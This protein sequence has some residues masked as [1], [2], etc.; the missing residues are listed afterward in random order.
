MGQDHGEKAPHREV[1]TRWDC[2]A[3]P[4]N[5]RILPLGG[6]PTEAARQIVRACAS[7]LSALRDAVVLIPDAHAAADF[8]Q[9]L[10][11]AAGREVLLLPRI[12]TLR[13]WASSVDAGKPVQ[14]RAVREALL[15]AALAGHA[16]LGE[17]DRWAVCSELLALF[18]ELT[19]H[20]VTLP[21]NTREF[22]R[23]V[24]KAYRARSNRSLDFEATLVHELWRLMSRD[25]NS[26]RELD[27]EAAY[28]LRLNALVHTHAPLHVVGVRRFTP[29]EQ[30][31]LERYAEHAPVSVYA[32]S[33][34]AGD[35][36]D[37]TLVAAWPALE[38]THEKAPPMLARANALREAAPASALTGRV[39]VYGA[40][41]AETE[42]RAVDVQVR[43]WL[44]AGKQRIAVIT[45]DRV[46]ARRARALLERA[47]VQV[48]DESG[49]PMAT[50]SA[51]TVLSR[52]LD[53][54]SGDAWHRDL[55][56]LMKSP[57]AF[58][59][60]PRDARQQ[61]VWRLE[62]YVR[63]D[64]VLSGI[65]NFIALAEDNNDAEV[66]QLLARVQ[67]ASHT[68]HALPRARKTLPRWLDALIASLAEIG[69][70][71][72]WRADSAGLQVFDL[73]DNLR[74]ELKENTLALG[75]A[76]WRRWLLR[77]LEAAS[78]V[79]SS[80]TSPV[81]FTHLGATPLRAFDA[82]LVLGC[83]A[84]HLGRGG[85]TPLFFNQSVRAQLGLPTRQ[86]EARDSEALLA[87]LVAST[88]RVVFTWQTHADA[89]E[90]LLAPPVERLLSLH[91]CAYNNLLTE[92]RLPALLAQTSLRC[93]DDS[94]P[95]AV[96]TKPAPPADNTLIPS[97]ISASSYN[98]LM[99]CPYQFHAR[100]LLRLGEVDEVEELID[101]SGYGRHVHAILTAFHQAHARVSDLD[102]AQALEQIEA[103][104]EQT[105][106]GAVG[107]NALAR[108][109]LMRWKSLIPAYLEWQRAREA[110]GWR[111]LAGEAKRELVIRTPVGR[112]FKLVGRLDR[113]DQHDSGAID[114]LDYKT[115]SVEALKKSLD[116]AGEDVQLPV[117]AL[118]WAQP[119]MAALYLSMDRDEIKTVAVPGDLPDIAHATRERLAQ[120]V[121]ALH[122][123]SPLPAQGAPQACDYCEMHGLCRR[124][125][126]A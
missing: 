76:E 59:D 90:N 54:V 24:E 19:R 75:F 108:G 99:T 50:T 121:D 29:A 103:L 96:A 94:A 16:S 88:P 53:V 112:E 98:T 79:E 40:P 49:W 113:V 84:R 1:A 7:D 101:K 71:D 83:D 85:D 87:Q 124:A 51:A 21:D 126:W 37:N 100:Y 64:S 38:K 118:L 48:R 81:V 52:W 26:A 2:P 61:A 116:T 11:V 65:N 34:G 14:P 77:Q 78:C 62:R 20:A 4:L 120:M 47:G 110:E 104:S 102:E 106:A 66:R 31:F 17:A 80:V 69:V 68:L 70:I 56:D 32:L 74:I 109:W 6:G 18:D 15:Y 45:L 41:D 91:H 123:A 82:A 107:R 35:A 72:G 25:A 30:T 114:V 86:D 58:H 9:A 3:M 39:S 36:M 10:R 8:A 105:F 27:A 28:A 22:T 13:L 122:D 117:Y 12:T 43:D 73:I 33:G 44:I 115:R 97:A 92:T 57:F 46:T 42:A 111:W 63:K 55:L 60:W 5:T 89:E 95:P 23:L 93:N 67:R 125:H 119:V